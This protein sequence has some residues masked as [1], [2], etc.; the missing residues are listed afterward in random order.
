MSWLTGSSPWIA[1]NNSAVGRG[2]A[3]DGGVK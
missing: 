3:Y 1:A 2:F